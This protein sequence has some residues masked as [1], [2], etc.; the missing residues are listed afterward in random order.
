MPPRAIKFAI[1]RTLR[2]SAGLVLVA[3]AGCGGAAPIP[4]LPKPPRLHGNQVAVVDGAGGGPITLRQLDA[5]VH[6]TYRLAREPIPGVFS[7][8]YRTTERAVIKDLLAKRWRHAELVDSGSSLSPLQLALKWAHRSF[9]LR[10]LVVEGACFPTTRLAIEE[11][12]EP[13]PQTPADNRGPGS[14]QPERRDPGRSPR[15]GGPVPSRERRDL[16][17]TD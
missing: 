7:A 9:C 3:M 12:A 13:S 10:D 11:P 5:A 17:T 1:F 16:P 15:T 4:R 8:S 14:R 6:K 2:L